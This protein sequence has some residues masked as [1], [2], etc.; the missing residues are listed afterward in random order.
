MDTIIE[1][2][3]ELMVSSSTGGNPTCRTA[4]FLKPCI[5]DSSS[6]S[7]SSF[8]DDIPHAMLPRTSLSSFHAKQPLEVRY[9][10]WLHPHEEWKKWVQQMQ[11]KYEYLW[12]KAGINQAIQASTC[13]IHRNDELIL[14]LAQ[15]WC[16]KTNTFI[17]PWG[18][19]TITLEDI[20]LCGGYSI[21]GDPFFRPLET[22]EQKE[23]E[24]ELIAVRRRFYKSKAKRADHKP[25][26]RHFMMR[27]VESRVEHEA[28]L[29]VWLSRFV[30]PATS[31]NSIVKCVFPIAIHLAR[32]T[33][34]ALAPAV[35]ASIYRDLT[36][37][38]NNVGIATINLIV[39]IWAPFQFLQIW[40]LER[41]QLQA[42]IRPKSH[43]IEHS[44][45]IMARWDG[46]KVPKIG[47]LESA[48]DYAGARNCFVWRPYM[49]SPS[50]RLYNE[51]DMWECDNPS[52]EHELQSFSRC[53][54]V[55]ELVGMGCIEQYFPHRVA[56]Q[57]GMDQ[58][59]PGRVAPCNKDPWLN[60]S[61]LIDDQ[62]L[63][64]TLCSCQY[65][66]QCQPNVTS[67][68]YIWWRQSNVSEDD[69]KISGFL[70]KC[71][72]YQVGDSDQEDDELL[73]K[74]QPSP[75]N[76]YRCFEDE[77][78]RNGARSN[79]VL[80]GSQR[81]IE[82]VKMED[83]VVGGEISAKEDVTS[84]FYD[85]PRKSKPGKEGGTINNFEHCV[86]NIRS[87]K[88][89]SPASPLQVKSEGSYGPSPGFNSKFKGDQVMD[90]DQNHKLLVI[91]L[92][93]S[94]SEDRCFEDDEVVGTTT[95]MTGG[96]GKF[97]TKG[98]DVIRGSKRTVENGQTEDIVRGGANS[99]AIHKVSES[100]LDN[101]IQKL[102]RMV[103]KMIAAKF[104]P[105]H[106]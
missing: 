11:P 51:K 40:A 24:A 5:K 23:A 41:F 102:K 38:S 53:L 21:L 50:L 93:S 6:S 14:G 95:S 56:M 35:L 58:D 19:A 63:C 25:W 3:K 29:C 22:Q 100:D 62:N 76:K 74:K 75:V 15:R 96:A 1:V 87:S 64:K 78:I 10:G 106:E 70:F 39:T 71:K 94:S 104:G 61:Q 4:Y 49:N 67:R 27:N 86:I 30:F 16:S 43:A 54:R 45:P 77:M 69:V 68:Y 88:H 37:L 97:F 72:R 80:T 31:L 89:L 36:L 7:S 90:C 42:L 47:N 9:N 101:R 46:V 13:H 92:S 98:K 81:I 57:F 34:I 18:E 8:S 91:E 52:I 105:K 32:G 85:W 33:R 2:K 79:E 20:N 17:F 12:I 66:S 48:L 44:E 60:Y 99:C 65:Q 82:D 26:M 83:D 28:F 84:R 55:C 59:I 103:D 73:D